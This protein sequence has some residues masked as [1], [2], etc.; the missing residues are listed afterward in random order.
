MG[1]RRK[2]EFL[3]TGR[4]RRCPVNHW[5]QLSKLY[6]LHNLTQ[7]NLESGLWTYSC[8]LIPRNPGIDDLLVD[9]NDD[10]WLIR[11]PDKSRD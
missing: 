4:T 3:M 10:L 1:R 8:D 6:S 11:N 2:G 9:K 7:I 5:R